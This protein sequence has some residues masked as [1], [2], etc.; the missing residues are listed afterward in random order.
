MGWCRWRCARIRAA[1]SDCRQIAEWHGTLSAQQRHRLSIRHP[2]S[3]PAPT[4]ASNGSSPA[5][6][7]PQVDRS[8]RAGRAS[9]SAPAHRPM[10]RRRR[11]YIQMETI[12]QLPE[13]Y[14]AWARENRIPQTGAQEATGR[15]SGGSEP[16]SLQPPASSLRLTSPDPNRVYRLDPVLPA[17]AQQRAGHGAAWR[18]LADG[19]RSSRCC[20]MARRSPGA[21]GRIHCLVAADRA[22][23]LPGHRD[24]DGRMAHV[25]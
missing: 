18:E 19:R 17:G 7:R 16:L 2:Q 1:A 5:R 8:H 12:W 24:T 25:Q 4:A 15:R 13:E 14:Q 3:S 10:P 20:W 9:T 21:A 23:H 6:S 22:A 11:E